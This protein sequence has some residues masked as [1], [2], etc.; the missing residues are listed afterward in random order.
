MYIYVHIYKFCSQKFLFTRMCAYIGTVRTP[1]PIDDD[2][3][4]SLCVA[5]LLDDYKYACHLYVYNYVFKPLVY[6]SN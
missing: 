4:V 3:L 5:Y 6:I 1:T 2:L